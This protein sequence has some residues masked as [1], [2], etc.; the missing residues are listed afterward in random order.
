MFFIRSTF[1]RN[2]LLKTAVKLKNF[3]RTNPG[4]IQENVK[5]REGSFKKQQEFSFL[6]ENVESWTLE[7]NVW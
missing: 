2:L 7:Q 1:I 3:S 4:K 5:N 6:S